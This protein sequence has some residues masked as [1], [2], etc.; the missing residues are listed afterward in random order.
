MTA[1]SSFLR[2]YG[3]WAL[4]TGA[5]SGIGAEFARQLAADGF[6][7]A[8]A[9]RREDLLEELAA[10]LSE[11]FGVAT[12]PI[13][14]DL[15]EEIAVDRLGSAVG[16]LDIGLVVSNAGTGNPGHF[17]KQDHA[18]Q[19]RLFRL[20]ALAHLN[21]AYL[22][23]RRLA[24]RGGGGLLLGGAMGAAHGIPFSANDAGA[25]ALVQSLGESLHVELR[26]QRVH[27]MTHVVPPTD[28]AII[29]KFGLDPAT[30]PLK[31]MS[32]AQCVSETL[33]AFRKGRSSFLPGRTNRIL[34]AL[35]P[36]FIMRVMMGRMIGQTL[37]KRQEQPV[38]I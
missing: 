2:H 5:S 24:Q 31:P 21:I 37:G 7:V 25:K 4:V 14:V 15:S 8:L 19:L 18:E 36:S 3:P 10:E 29:R 32:T 30:M 13:V 1:V 23:G 9:A 38:P 26:R 35:I 17:L 34:R 27:V 12:R 16:D 33:R 28:T 22:F 11:R 20:N 6:H